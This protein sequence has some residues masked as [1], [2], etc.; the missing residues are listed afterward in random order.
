MHTFVPSDLKDIEFGSASDVGTGGME[1]KVLSALWALKNGT[2]VVI[3]NGMEYNSI[4]R[5]FKGERCGSFFTNAEDVSVPVELL[6][7]NGKISVL[8]LLCNGG[9]S[10]IFK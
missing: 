10:N 3:C 9:I 6:A 4:R 1:S 5:I 2:S 8:Y 7:Q